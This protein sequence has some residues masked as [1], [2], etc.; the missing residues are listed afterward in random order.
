MAGLIYL[1][2]LL[3]LGLAYPEENNWTMIARQFKRKETLFNGE[4]LSGLNSFT[5]DF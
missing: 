2:K 3:S 4:M 1:Y 5:E